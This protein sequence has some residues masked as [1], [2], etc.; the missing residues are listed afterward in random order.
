MVKKVSVVD[1]YH[2]T[3]IYDPYRWMEDI[4]SDEVKAFVDEHNIKSEEYIKSYEGY[5]A[6]KDRIAELWRYESYSAPLKKGQYY[7]FF[8]N[9]GNSNQPGL[10]RA[11]DIKGEKFL[12]V[13]PSEYSEDS[14]SSIGAIAV[15][16]KKD[17]LAYSISQKGSDWQVIKML[18]MSTMTTLKEEIQWCRFTSITWLEDNERFIYSRYPQQ[19][20]ME[21]EELSYHNMVCI[22]RLGTSQDEDEVLIDGSDRSPYSNYVSLSYDKKYILLEKSIGT[23]TE[24]LV[25]LKEIDDAN[26][27][28]SP[29][30][31]KNGFWY[32]LGNK[33]FKFYFLT[34]YNAPKNRIVEIDIRNYKEENWIEI[35]PEYATDTITDAIYNDGYIFM[36]VMHDAY[37]KAVLINLESKEAT[38]LEIGVMGAISEISCGEKGKEIFF[39]FASYFIPNTIY[40]V[41]LEHK[42]MEKVLEPRIP[43]DFSNYETKQVFVKSKDGTR[44]PMFLNYKKGIKLNGENKTVLYAYGG[45]NLNRIPEFRVPEVVWMERGGIYAVANIRGGNEYGEQWHKAG[46]LENKQNC[47]DD[48]IS[49]G[50]YLI[51]EKYTSSKKL[52]IRG[53][54]NGGLLTGAC[55]V[56]RPELYGAVITQVGVLDMLRYHK[57]TIGRF[58]IPEY[59]DAENNPEHFKFMIKYSPLHNIRSGIVYPP[60]FVPTGDNDDR[61]LP[62]HSYKYVATL[63]EVASGVN[64]ILLKV[65][66]N[67]GHGQGKPISKL[68]EVEADI[69]SF[70]E[71]ALN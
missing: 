44:I 26:E 54:S 7:Y 18:D 67:A 5:E 70:L 16:E 65:E 49:C 19:G 30:E 13:D 57:Y 9:D 48:F 15:N 45:F 21:D 63:E 61:V 42:T 35:V 38:Y 33:S 28:F 34:N 10:Y 11:K 39:L 58:W 25:Y 6:I 23:S 40:K 46:M 29:V 43:L 1:N 52:A 64:P 66:K 68:I 4:H 22:H 8:Y 59:G 32:F 24:N 53:R 31:G 71:K 56:Q 55:M 69:Y 36:S 3:K 2:G 41:N 51:E 60:V 20:S 27:F 47:F 14:T 62:C 50:E 12:L 37:H 17:I